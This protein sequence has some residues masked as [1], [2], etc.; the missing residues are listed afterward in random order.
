MCHDSAN[1][2]DAQSREEF[3]SF[4]YFL[5]L[6]TFVIVVYTDNFLWEKLMIDSCAEAINQYLYYML[7]VKSPSEDSPSHVKSVPAG[8]AAPPL[9]DRQ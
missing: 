4:S 5:Y 9:S 7:S 2:H 6:T 3:P 8:P 1:L